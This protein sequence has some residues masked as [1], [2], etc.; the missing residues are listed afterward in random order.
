[1][2]LPATG[3]SLY[4]ANRNPE[5]GFEGAVAACPAKLNLFLEVGSRRLDGYHELETVIAP[6]RLSDRLWFRRRDDNE[7][8]LVTRA[9]AG[10][11][12]AGLPPERD[13]LVWRILDGFRQAAGIVAGANLLLE[14]SV[15]LQAGLGGASSDAAA[16]LR[17][18]NQEWRV[19]W[20]VAEL[21]AFAGRFGSDI[22][23]FL[24]GGWAVCRGRGEIVTRLPRGIRC[25]VV[26][27][28]P[29]VGFSTAEIYRRH[30]P[31]AEARSADAILDAITQGKTREIGRELFNRLETAASGM[32]PWLE[33][34]AG[35]VRV[36]PVIGQQLTGSGS[37]YFGMFPNTPVARRSAQRLQ[38]VLP[39]CRVILSELLPA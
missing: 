10:L 12:L 24:A 25:P 31:A 14:K 35:A 36:L 37:C 18:A 39:E 32:G 1:M 26:L 34:L 21:Q 29:P 11:A 6:L 23:F 33:R 13:N 9:Q 3:A 28:Q 15:P 17:L 30:R 8:Q 22:P 16:A 20:S 7:L 27:V 4:V 5:T 19:G 2:R 38:A